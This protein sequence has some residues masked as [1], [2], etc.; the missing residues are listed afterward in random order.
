MSKNK[1]YIYWN[2]NS[3]MKYLSLSGRVYVLDAFS[4]KE[5]YIKCYIRLIEL[6]IKE[7]PDQKI[8]KLWG[9]YGKKKKYTVM[10][11]ANTF[12]L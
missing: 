9:D 7:Y 2:F 8:F 4:K 5:I 10:V 6:Y 1:K 11:C 3:I 12:W